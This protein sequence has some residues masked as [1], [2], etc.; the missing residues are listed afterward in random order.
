M[1]KLIFQSTPIGF[2]FGQIVYQD[3]TRQ[4]IFIFF[5]FSIITVITILPK[6]DQNTENT[7]FFHVK[8]KAFRACPA[9]KSYQNRILWTKWS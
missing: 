5:N 8:M 6:T 2:I 4:W 9:G 3:N 7:T 1:F